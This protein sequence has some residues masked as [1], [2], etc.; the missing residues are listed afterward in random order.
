MA[1]ALQTHVFYEGKDTYRNGY[2]KI[3]DGT[4][5]SLTV[6][7]H[8]LLR[9]TPSKHE[10]GRLDITIHDEAGG[11][12]EFLIRVP[13]VA[14]EPEGLGSSVRGYCGSDAARQ[15]TFTKIDN[16]RWARA[17][18]QNSSASSIFN[19]NELVVTH[20]LKDTS[21]PAEPPQGAEPTGVGAT[22]KAYCDGCD[23]RVLLVRNFAGAWN[24]QNENH[25][26]TWEHLQEIGKPEVVNAGYE[27]EEDDDYEDH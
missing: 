2:G 17:G 11:V 6:N 19:W 5:M 25:V 20:V 12:E 1:K 23:R 15:D 18:A 4:P 16:G 13:H 8:Q 24:C 3:A 14:E 7:G 26:H 21:I 9:I 27:E 10:P 22:A